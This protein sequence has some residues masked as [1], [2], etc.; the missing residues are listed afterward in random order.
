MKYAALPLGIAILAASII[1]ARAQIPVDPYGEP[2]EDK[3]E[4][5][6]I[7]ALLKKRLGKIDAI[8]CPGDNL[9]SVSGRL[10][11]FCEIKRKPAKVGRCRSHHA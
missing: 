8:S 11:W 5:T 1:T 2:C 7:F 3:F 6:K 10:L 4:K 9:V